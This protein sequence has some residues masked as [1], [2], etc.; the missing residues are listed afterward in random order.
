MF[1]YIGRLVGT[2][3]TVSVPQTNVFLMIF[4]TWKPVFAGIVKRWQFATIISWQMCW[5]DVL[6]QCFPR[7]AM[8]MHLRNN[9]LEFR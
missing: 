9:D 3:E 7:T 6:V 4:D 2:G 5:A 8:E 1:G